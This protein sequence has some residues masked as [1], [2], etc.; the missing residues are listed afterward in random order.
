MLALL[1]VEFGVF[2]LR[3]FQGLQRRCVEIVLNM[4]C[5]LCPHGAERCPE[6]FGVRFDKLAGLYVTGFEQRRQFDQHLPQQRSIDFPGG[7]VG[8]LRGIG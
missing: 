8:S 6:Q 2:A 7:R 1:A 5:Q 4:L 3:L